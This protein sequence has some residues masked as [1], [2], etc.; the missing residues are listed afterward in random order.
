MVCQGENKCPP[1]SITSHNIVTTPDYSRLAVP[2]IVLLSMTK[3][4]VK[5]IHAWLM[6]ILYTIS[7]VLDIPKNPAGSL[8]S[9]T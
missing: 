3:R 9:A 1:Q 4:Y 2:L 8:L 7:V 5:K 6:F